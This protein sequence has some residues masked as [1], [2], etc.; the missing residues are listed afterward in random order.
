MVR[1]RCHSRK[2]DPF[3]NDEI[4]RLL[5][6]KRY[7]QPPPDYFENFLQSFAVA[8]V[9]NCVANPFG[10]SALIARTIL[11][12]GT[13]SVL[14]AYPA[15]IAAVVACAAVIS[16]TIYQQPDTTQF[17]V[18]SSPVPT[19][20]PNTEKELDFA[21]PVL[22]PAFDTQPAVLPANS[23]AIRMLPVPPADLLRSDQF[24][25]LK[26]E[27]E[28][29][30]DQPLQRN[31]STAEKSAGANPARLRVSPRPADSLKLRFLEHHF[32]QKLVPPESWFGFWS[33]RVISSSA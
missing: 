3:G 26:L 4:A 11:C 22:I 33:R 13:M 25:P 30:D 20:S 17:A 24:V 7:E 23:R 10:A 15:G 18:Q 27:W 19:R 6:L 29:L 1:L 28:S 31:K 14:A 9:T 21:P 2:M 16:I 32:Q 5:R 12:S 8:S